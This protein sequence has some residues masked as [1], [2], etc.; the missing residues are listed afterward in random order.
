MVSEGYNYDSEGNL[1]SNPENQLFQY[2]AENRQTQVT[3]TASNTTA[4]Y[5]YD[6]GGK[7]VRKTFGN[8]ETIFVYDAFGKMVAEYSN[9][10]ET[11]PKSVSYLTTDALG[12]PRI[13][14]DQT[15]QVVS[16]HDYMPFGEE[17]MANVGG[18]TTVQGYAGND[19]VKQQFT[20]YERDGESGLDYAQARYFSSKHGRFTSV[21]PLTA[22][23]SMK[24]PQTF[25][26]YSYA[27]NSPY[28]FVDPLG[29]KS[30]PNRGCQ[31]G[32]NCMGSG[33]GYDD[34][35]QGEDAEKTITVNASAVSQK[36][37]NKANAKRIFE[38]ASQG[39]IDD[40]GSMTVS[41]YDATFSRGVAVMLV[42]GEAGLGSINVGG[43]FERSARTRQKEL[44][45]AGIIAFI[46]KV[47]TVEGFNDA[48]AIAGDQQTADSLNRDV[49]GIEIFA[50]GKKE[51][52]NFGEGKA[53]NTNFTID[54]VNSMK[55]GFKG[56]IRINA[57]NTG[58][59]TYNIASKISSKLGIIVY[60]PTTGMSFS[61][62]PDRIMS[63][64][65]S[66]TG[67]TYM[68]PEGGVWQ[69]F[70]P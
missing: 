16:R 68:I 2:D 15:G 13:I 22:S 56:Y 44:E 20:G 17:V 3:N 60:A 58:N 53:K 27:M 21:D 50:H 6:G 30:V 25:N 29:L 9:I 1:T 37:F 46:W 42:Y 52:I 57:C 19:G 40:S 51:E 63:S 59:G 65:H 70:K 69:T 38:R 33:Q 34:A 31:G 18:R 62:N 43:N 8:E 36:Q 48:L 61:S 47:A 11:H 64:V 10:I 67:P 23:A 66:S 55:T 54:D 32:Q 14:T 45:A 49:V 24:N 26:R 4:N 7:R 41:M 28:K 5:Q 12:S 35:E 39:Y